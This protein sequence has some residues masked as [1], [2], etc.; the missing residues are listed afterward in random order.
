MANQL[1]L[2]NEEDLENKIERSVLKAF[3]KI[4]PVV[5]ETGPKN[6]PEA[7]D[8][9]RM[10]IST[11]RLYLKKKEV[12]G[13]KVGKEWKFYTKDLDDFIKNHRN[14]KKKSEKLVFTNP[15]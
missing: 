7:A 10:P 14:D 8:Y 9:C 11:F 13:S 2:I 3:S 6:L 5:L 4:Q 15:K 1:L 12:I